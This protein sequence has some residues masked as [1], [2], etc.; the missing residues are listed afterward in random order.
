MQEVDAITGFLSDRS[1]W[2]RT[3]VPVVFRGV[4]LQGFADKHPQFRD[5]AAAA[6]R[7][8]EDVLIGGTRTLVA[9][10]PPGTGKT[11]LG[12]AI[13]N[14]VAPTCLIATATRAQPLREL[15]TMLRS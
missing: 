15:R 1:Q 13:W 14:A 9:Y 3:F 6:Q 7:Y 8:V 11:E 12:C 5:Q 4:S 10:G 2:T